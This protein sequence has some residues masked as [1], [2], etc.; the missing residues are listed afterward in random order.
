MENNLE[1]C[2]YGF[3]PLAYPKWQ[4]PNRQTLKLALGR[5]MSSTSFD[6]TLHI[7]DDVPGIE[8]SLQNR[9]VQAMDRYR[10]EVTAV[11]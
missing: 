11:L 1:H 6:Q 4:D 9:K 7:T 5:V 3:N 8:V 2:R 10:P